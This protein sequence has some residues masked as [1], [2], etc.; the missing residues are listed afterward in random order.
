MKLAGEK[1]VSRDAGDKAAAIFRHGGDDR[2]IFGDNIERVH[3]VNIVAT[4]D[5]F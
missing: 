4:G 3:E 1:V 2:R 5:S